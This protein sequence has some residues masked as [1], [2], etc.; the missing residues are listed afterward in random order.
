M[1]ALDNFILAGD[2]ILNYGCTDPTAIN[3][4]PLSNVDDAS[5]YSCDNGLLDGNETGIDCGGPDCSPCLIPC[6]Q[7]ELYIEEV[8]SDTTISNADFIHLSAQIGRYDVKLEPG[9]SATLEAGF[10]LDLG[11]NFEA[12]VKH[13]NN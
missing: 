7:A 5:C 8:Q 12:T 1:I 10:N 11:A 6:E 4:D 9:I 13:C 3:F 2:R